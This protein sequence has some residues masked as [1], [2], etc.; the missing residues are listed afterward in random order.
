[1]KEF[2]ACDMGRYTSLLVLSLIRYSYSLSDPLPPRENEIEDFILKGLVQ[3][4]DRGI[5]HLLLTPLD[6]DLGVKQTSGH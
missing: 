1:M 6:W 3:P 2:G 4:T 5:L